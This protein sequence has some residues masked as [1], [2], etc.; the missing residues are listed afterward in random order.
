MIRPI[1]FIL[2]ALTLAALWLTPW[3]SWGVAPFSSH[4]I[5][6]M[7][8]VAVAAPLLALGLAG[9]AFDPVARWPALFP[10]IL[11]SLLEFVIVWVWHT[12]ALHH[13]ARHLDL[14][15]VAEQGT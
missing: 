14:A 13:A 15:F 5:V 9:T 6:H 3:V 8:I 10:P 12:P 11:V 1:I 2:A 7:G 4:M